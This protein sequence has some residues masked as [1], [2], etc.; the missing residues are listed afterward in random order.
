MVMLNWEILLIVSHWWTLMVAVLFWTMP[1]QFISL[2]VHSDNNLHR[3][4]LGSL[5][6]ALYEYWMDNVSIYFLAFA[7]ACL[8]ACLPSSLSW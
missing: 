6:W 4:D 5:G 7:N 2:L 8:P 3:Y 1:L